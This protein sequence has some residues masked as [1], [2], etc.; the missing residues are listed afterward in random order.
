MAA[1]L[2]IQMIWIHKASC[3]HEGTMSKC[4]KPT[5][6]LG[7]RCVETV[8]AKSFLGFSPVVLDWCTN[9]LSGWSG[10]SENKIDADSF[11]RVVEGFTQLL[12]VYFILSY[13]TNNLS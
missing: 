9:I 1:D 13:S 10:F 6:Q 4:C 3:S 2:C 7:K 5:S 8:D 11:L 12:P